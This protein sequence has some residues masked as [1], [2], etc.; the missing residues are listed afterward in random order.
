MVRERASQ[1]QSL[2]S[3]GILPEQQR[4]LSRPTGETTLKDISKLE[5]VNLI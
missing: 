3:E 5:I 2:Q 4:P 1:A